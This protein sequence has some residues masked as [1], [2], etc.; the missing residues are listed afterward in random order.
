M[1]RVTVFEQLVC[2]WNVMF[3]FPLN[4]TVVHVLFPSFYSGGKRGTETK[5][6]LNARPESEAGGG[7]G[8]RSVL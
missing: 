2:P 8:L 7:T 1:A 6:R 5:E 3:L 4:F